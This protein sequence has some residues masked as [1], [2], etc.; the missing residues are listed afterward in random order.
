MKKS[1][2]T[3]RLFLYPLNSFINPIV[4]SMNCANNPFI[5]HAVSELVCEKMARV[6]IGYSDCVGDYEFEKKLNRDWAF[7]VVD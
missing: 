7:F 6:G 1:A 5:G 4:L 3:S 2:K